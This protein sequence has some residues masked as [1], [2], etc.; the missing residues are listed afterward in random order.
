MNALVDNDILLKAACL[1]LLRRLL[2]HNPAQTGVLTASRY[3]LPPKVRR[4]RTG[5]EGD[6]VLSELLQYIDSA[7]ELEPTPRETTLAADLERTALRAGLELDAGESQLCAVSITRQVPVLLTG[8]KRA[9]SAFEQLL[10]REPRTAALAGRVYSLEQLVASL[11]RT[12]DVGTLK[13]AVCREPIVDRALAMC[14]SCATAQAQ[15]DTILQG[16]SSYIGSLRTAARRVLAPD[17]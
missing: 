12:T 17:P 15:R 8:D 9:V 10:D 4:L 2:P 3:V 5:A 11:L 16:L 6:A 14:F 7:T 13:N 1:R